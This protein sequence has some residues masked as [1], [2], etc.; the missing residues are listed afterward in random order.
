MDHQTAKTI[1]LFVAKTLK[2]SEKQ[3]QFI[4]KG[5]IEKLHP[6]THRYV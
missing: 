3:L 1:Q 2:Y 5:I 4:R 6:D